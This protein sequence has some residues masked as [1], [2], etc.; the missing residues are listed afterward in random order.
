MQHTCVL[1]ARRIF[2]GAPIRRQLLLCLTLAMTLACGKSTTPASEGDPRCD[3]DAQCLNG[4]HC[5]QGVCEKDC[6]SDSDCLNGFRCATGVCTEKTRCDSAGRCLSGFACLDGYCAAVASGSGGAGSS[7]PS[8]STMGGIVNAVTGMVSQGGSGATPPPTSGLDGAGGGGSAIPSGQGGTAP[9][10]TQAAQA[11]AA[12][13]PNRVGSVTP[14]SSGQLQ[15]IVGSTCNGQMVEPPRAPAKLAIVIDLSSSMNQAAAGTGT[16]SKYEVLRDALLTVIAD[17]A[18]LDPSTSVGML[19]YPNLINAEVMTKPS[20]TSTCIRI[21]A[22]V[23]SKPLG[24][25]NSPERTALANA[26]ADA[27]LG[28]GTP[29]EDA[30]AWAL[31]NLL[32]TAEQRAMP[33]ASHVLLITD[34]ADPLSGLP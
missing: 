3:S 32:L 24:P 27:I 33:G 10:Q 15:Q 17:P 7:S 1:G 2:W 20:D 13:V 19:L 14:I 29:T 9:N 26:F 12:S 23:A 11:G 31:E 6:G 22:A 18:S 30:Y 8:D 34:G 5:A 25:A 28:R 4:Y 21:D 16:T